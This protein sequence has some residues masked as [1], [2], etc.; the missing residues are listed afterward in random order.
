MTVIDSFRLHVSWSP[1][2]PNSVNGVIR[3][4]IINLTVTETLGYRQYSSEN[5]SLVITELHPF[6]TYTVYIAAVTIG[7][8]PLSFGT[9]I[10][11]PQYGE[12]LIVNEIY[13]FQYYK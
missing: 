11:M 13:L 7:S 8:G 3:N 4:Y 10:R 2:S 9:S 1:P 12:Y 6:F 5:T